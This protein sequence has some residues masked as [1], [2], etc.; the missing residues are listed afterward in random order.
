MLADTTSLQPRPHL[1]PS[2]LELRHSTTRIQK[3][4][5]MEKASTVPQRRRTRTNLLSPVI[6]L[7]LVDKVGEDQN[8]F[9]LELC[10]LGATEHW[11]QLYVSR[12]RTPGS[13]AHQ[14]AA[15]GSSDCMSGP[16]EGFQDHI[17][18]RNEK[19]Q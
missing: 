13:A 16:L 15:G 8:P 9:A 19:G 5:C 4:M 6:E 12:V 18:S 14:R 2:A 7:R 3:T 1:L 11:H 17:I 10:N